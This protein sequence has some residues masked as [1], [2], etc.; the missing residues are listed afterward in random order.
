MNRSAAETSRYDDDQPPIPRELYRTVNQISLQLERAPSRNRNDQQ[1][2]FTFPDSISKANF[3]IL[4]RA[5]MSNTY[6]MMH[7]VIVELRSG[8]IILIRSKD[9]N[10]WRDW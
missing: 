8:K 10:F 5:M 7:G 9:M 6:L 1:S 3:K 4:L 2:Y